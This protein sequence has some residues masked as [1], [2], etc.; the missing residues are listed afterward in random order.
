MNRWNMSVAR[1]DALSEPH[2]SAEACEKRFTD[3]GL[4]L[5]LVPTEQQLGWPKLAAKI[6]EIVSRTFGLEKGEARS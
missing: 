4:H 3:A 6:E 2:L 1:V 5:G